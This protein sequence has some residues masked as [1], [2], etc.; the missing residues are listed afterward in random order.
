MHTKQSPQP[1]S[2]QYLSA[3]DIA[4]AIKRSRYGVKCAINRLGIE[5]AITLGNIRYYDPDVVTNI[6]DNMRRANGLSAR[7]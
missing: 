5:P 6:A 2:P 3:A 1:K 4:S 7:A